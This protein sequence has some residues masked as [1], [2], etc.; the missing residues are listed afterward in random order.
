MKQGTVLALLAMVACSA[1]RP[2]PDLLASWNG[3]EIRVAEL[4]TYLLSLPLGQRSPGPEQDPEEWLTTEVERL[5]ER[6]A[7]RS[8]GELAI[9]PA[10]EAAWQERSLNALRQA[11]MQRKDDQ[12]DITL[13]E[14]REQWEANRAAF[15]VPET[16]LFR[17]LFLAFPEGAGE[18]KREAVCAQVEDLRR[19]VVQGASFTELIHRH[20][21][22]ANA[23]L[24][25]LIGPA[26]RE[27]LR[28]EAG[29]L[30]FSL[31]PGI[32]SSV[33]ATPAGCQIFM[34]QQVRPAEE[35][36]FE[37]VAGRLV[38][39]IAERRRG[40]W[41]RELLD[42]E[43]SKLGVV[44]P[45]W[46]D[47]TPPDDLA[48]DDVVLTVGERSIT[49]GEA[50]QR[51]RTASIPTA[52]ALRLMAEQVVFSAALETEFPE[53]AAD[54]LA[55]LRVLFEDTLRRSSSLRSFFADQPEEILRDHYDDHLSRFQSDPRVELTIYSWPIAEGDPLRSMARP[56]AFAKSLLVNGA[57]ANDIWEEYAGDAGV[58]RQSLPQMSLRE[59]INRVPGTSAALAS[60]VFEGAVRGPFRLGNQLVVLQVDV[61]IPSRQLS[62]LE[63]LDSVRADLI[64]ER[65]TELEEAWR[66][67]LAERFGLR[68]FAD[69]I[70][71]FGTQLVDRLL[72][73][74]G[75]EDPVP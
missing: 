46:M 11:F 37:L 5:F 20:S 69:N 18:E 2:D 64:R 67:D 33:L 30:V 8:E 23:A 15:R 49:W 35:G 26:T 39:Q 43:S 14:A 38:Q 41:R 66:Q 74:V 65:G 24:G 72:E 63:A 70:A 27:Q 59:I 42:A 36:R 10:E 48:V 62:Y 58:S 52:S 51:G 28:G 17:N 3:G 56:R 68:L 71:A 12:F 13:D 50:Q 53:V 40:V 29:E 44:L 16:R 7:L 57:M 75:Q 21:E 45:T 73:N 55:K 6:D 60:D 25:G 19:Q 4:D 47:E 22:S 34:I 9:G 1:P 31:E 61:Y 54:I 32:I